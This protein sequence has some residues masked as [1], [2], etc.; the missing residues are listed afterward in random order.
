LS[1]IAGAHFEGY[2]EFDGEKLLA[3]R[4][5]VRQTFES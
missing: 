3:H 5:V 2:F 4:I 1:K